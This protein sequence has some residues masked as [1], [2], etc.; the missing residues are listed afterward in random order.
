MPGETSAFGLVGS[1]PV[2]LLPGR[3]DAALAAWLVVGRRLLA[4]LHGG[5]ED[6]PAASARLSRKIASTVGIAEV[7]PVRRH[8]AEVEPIA[9]GVLPLQS[10]SRADGWVLVPADSEGHSAGTAVD[11]RPLP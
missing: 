8:G 5:R 7:V 4:R 3:L 1:R 2:L 11:V 10:L 6:E 9:T